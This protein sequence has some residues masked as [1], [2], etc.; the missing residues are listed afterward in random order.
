MKNIVQIGTYDRPD[1]NISEFIGKDG[2]NIFLIEGN[3]IAL[4]R[5]KKC[6]ESYPNII[7]GNFL[8]SNY[9]GKRKFY[10]YK[11]QS[12]PSECHQIHSVLKTHLEGHGANSNWIEEVELECYTLESTLK[13]FNIKDQEIDTLFLDTEGHDSDIIIST[14]FS[15]INIK[16]ML[17]EIQ[18]SDGV[19]HKGIKLSNIINHLHSFNYTLTEVD[20]GF[21]MW[22]K[23]L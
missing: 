2:Y 21:N 14:D 3:I 17:F 4:E 18:H 19:H 20:N 23:K 8:V 1:P 9:D 15:K 7:Y 16:N 6:L 10:I 12:N 13:L 22:A 11:D 5:L